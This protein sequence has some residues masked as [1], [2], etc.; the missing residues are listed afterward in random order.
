MELQRV[1]VPMKVKEE[2][3]GFISWKTEYPAEDSIC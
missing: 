2:T 3:N 1:C